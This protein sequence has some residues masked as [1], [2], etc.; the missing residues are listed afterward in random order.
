MKT[1]TR[2][3]SFAFL[4]GLVVSLSSS[5]LLSSVVGE[6]GGIC[7]LHDGNGGM[8]EG[9]L[10]RVVGPQKNRGNGLI[11]CSGYVY[12]GTGAHI[13]LGKK[14]TGTI[15]FSQAVGNAVTDNWR[16]IIR[17]NGSATLICN[18]P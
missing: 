16:Q 14:E 3:L 17:P 10:D 9:S 7:Y 12:N 4:L 2:I 11:Q 6:E 1:L 13:S 15:C 18:F 5:F 8:V